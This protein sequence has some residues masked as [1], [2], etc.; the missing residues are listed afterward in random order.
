MRATATMSACLLQTSQRD[1]RISGYSEREYDEKG[2]PCSPFDSC[3]SARTAAARDEAPRFAT[4]R[5]RST[6][7]VQVATND[8]RAPAHRALERCIVA[9]P[10]LVFRQRLR[11]KFSLFHARNLEDR[12]LSC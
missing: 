6:F 4:A 8:E 12:R 9:V 1:S 5:T 7:P 2:I 3:A 11:V 10:I